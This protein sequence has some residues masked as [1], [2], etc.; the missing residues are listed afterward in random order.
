MKK[1]TCDKELCIESICIID[2]A[3]NNGQKGFWADWCPN[4]NRVIFGGFWW[5]IPDMDIDHEPSEKEVDNYVNLFDISDGD[6]V[7]EDERDFM[8]I[9]KR[10]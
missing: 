10:K 1:C 5:N 2:F 7:L 8:A 6:K 9:A 3:G 4:S